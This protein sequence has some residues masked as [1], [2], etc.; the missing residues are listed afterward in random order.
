MNKI[1]NAPIEIKNITPDGYIEG[2]AAVFGNTDSYGHRIKKGA[3]TKTLQQWSEKNKPLPILW[4]HDQSCPIGKATALSEDDYGLLLCGSLLV[5]DIQQARE[6]RALAQ[7][8]VVDGLSIGFI[9]NDFDKNHDGTIELKEVELLEVSVVMNPANEESRIHS[10]KS[11]GSD[12]SL[13]EFEAFLRDAGGFSKSKATAIA[14][15]GYRQMLSDSAEEVEVKQQ[16]SEVLNILK[17][18]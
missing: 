12:M 10:I 14:S 13:K 9:R 17:G 1:F 16:L 8:G 18:I 5:D 15:H 11:D 6:A 7:Q 3:F 2:Y 4:S